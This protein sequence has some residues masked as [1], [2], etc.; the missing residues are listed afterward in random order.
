MNPLR[1]PFFWAFLSMFALVVSPVFMSNKKFGNKAWLGVI[2]G[3]VFRGGRLFLVL[4]FCLQPRLEVG[5]WHLVIGGLIYVIGVY[6]DVSLWSIKP[7]TAPDDKVTLQTT[8]LYGIV[9]NPSYLGEV[10]WPLG[11]AIMFRST[12]G[13]ALTPLWWVGLLCL[14]IIEEQSLERELGQPY[15]E[16]KE[17]VRGRIIPGLPI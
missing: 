9:R 6:F 14:I 8:G 16:Y 17:K 4:P 7:F 2:I 3:F 11:L 1:N 13:I 15:L 5:G 12:I 10:L